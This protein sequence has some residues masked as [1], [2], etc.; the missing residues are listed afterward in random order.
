M[1]N[2]LTMPDATF[3][4]YKNLATAP[5]APYGLA[6][7]VAEVEAQMAAFAT[8]KAATADYARENEQLRRENDIGAEALEAVVDQLVR[9]Q[10][11][12]VSSA[13]AS[14]IAPETPIERFAAELAIKDGMSEAQ[15][16]D[17]LERAEREALNKGPAFTTGQWREAYGGVARAQPKTAIEKLA[18]DLAVKDDFE[19]SDWPAYLTKAERRVNNVVRH[20]SAN[21]AAAVAEEIAAACT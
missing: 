13:F 20:M 19:T 10:G 3:T 8:E 14:V 21:M 17:Y 4:A 16:P 11:L 2:L 18:A 9:T 5:Y 7:L 15:W 6:D 12:L 1:T